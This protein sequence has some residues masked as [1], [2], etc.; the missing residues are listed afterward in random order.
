L[1]KLLFYLIGGDKSS[2]KSDMGKKKFEIIIKKIENES[3]KF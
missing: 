3:T 1:K 2:Q